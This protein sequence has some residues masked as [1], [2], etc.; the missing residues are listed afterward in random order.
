VSDLIHIDVLICGAGA[1]GL[2]LAVDLARRGVDFRLIEKTAGPFA[3]SRGKGLQPRSQEVLEDLGVLDRIVATGGPYPPQRLHSPDGT[4]E[5]ATMFEPSEA[6]PA[7]PYV[8]PL[9]SPQFLTERALRDRLAEFGQRPWFG[10][11]LVGFEQDADGVTARIVG[12]DGAEASLRC[13]YLVGCDGGRSFVR[14]SLG[15]EFPGTTLGVRAVVADVGMPGLSTDAWHR[16]GEGADQIGLCPLRDTG[17]VQL[18]APVPLEGEVDLTADGL[19][20]MVAART[21][22]S[23]LKVTEVAWASAYSMNARLADRYRIGRVL[24]AGDAAHIHPPTGGQGLNTGLQDAYNLGWKLAAVLAGAPDSLLDSYEA[25]RRPVASEVLGLSKRL[26][27]DAKDGGPMRRGRETRQLDIGYPGS[28]LSL[29][30]PERD[31][32]MA[33]DRAPDAT[34]RRAAGQPVRLFDLFAG[35][36]WTL[37]GYEAARATAP[38]ARAGVQAHTV[39]EAGEIV[40]DGGHIQAAYGLAPGDWVLVRPDGYVA[41]VGAAEAVQAHLHRLLGPAA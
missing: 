16:F 13:R 23:D 26:L 9:L 15:I 33:G 39:G 37:L 4:F 5:D 8:T 17:L 11:E 40:D 29:D 7:E 20:A 35:P 25:E 21:G 22:R 32:V 3:G 18:Q 19:S 27:D 36:H 14:H 24:L 6:T 2:A 28:P 38:R 10:S 41:A 1:A 31:G 30:G 12:P 34:C